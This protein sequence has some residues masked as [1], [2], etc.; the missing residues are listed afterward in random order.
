MAVIP[1]RLRQNSIAC[2]GKLA[3]PGILAV[4]EQGVEPG[5]TGSREIPADASAD[6]PFAEM[7]AAHR[8]TE[9]AQRLLDKNAQSYAL[10]RARTVDSIEMACI[11]LETDRA[12]LAEEPALLGVI[13]TNSP[14]Q[15]D[16]QMSEAVIELAGAGQVCC[17]TPFTL[18]GSMSRLR[19]QP[20]R[21]SPP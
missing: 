7:R 14:L 9:F 13:N 18:A 15:L 1:A 10:G 21:E 12:G 4:I 17:I 2:S 6:L 19:T 3:S 11:A 8:I 20:A 16:I 5:A